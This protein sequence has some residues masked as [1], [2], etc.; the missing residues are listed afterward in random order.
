MSEIYAVPEK[1]AFSVVQ[2]WKACGSAVCLLDL[3]ALVDIW[4][5]ASWEDSDSL[6]TCPEALLQSLTT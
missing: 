3:V 6:A 4:P 2:V 1:Y 5:H